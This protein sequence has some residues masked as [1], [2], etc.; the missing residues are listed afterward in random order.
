MLALVRLRRMNPASFLTIPNKSEGFQS[1]WNDSIIKAVI[2]KEFI[3][4]IT[5]NTNVVIVRIDRTI[6]WFL[7]APIKSEHDIVI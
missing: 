2:T 4:K 1:S 6:Q 7:D 3:S 5:C